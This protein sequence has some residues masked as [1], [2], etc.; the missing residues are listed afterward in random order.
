MLPAGSQNNQYNYLSE[1]L[2]ELLF[3][4]ES[5]LSEDFALLLPSE[6]RFAF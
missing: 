4:L 3:D 2:P 6:E 5:E 1:V